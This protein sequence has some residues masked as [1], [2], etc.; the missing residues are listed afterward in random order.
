MRGRSVPVVFLILDR[1]RAIVDVVFFDA[2]TRAGVG[3]LFDL[4]RGKRVRQ[5]AGGF[6]VVH[7]GLDAFPSRLLYEGVSE[8]DVVIPKRPILPLC[9]FACPP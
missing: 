5:L 6:G 7:H 3:E 8:L 4:L 1:P 2:Q 9:L